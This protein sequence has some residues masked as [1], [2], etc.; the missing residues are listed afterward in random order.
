M[1]ITRSKLRATPVQLHF[2]V[3]KKNIYSQVSK[4]QPDYKINVVNWGFF[5]T[6]SSL[7]S[8]CF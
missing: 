2:F 5:L 1:K 6:A 3:K 4:N 8:N 7:P